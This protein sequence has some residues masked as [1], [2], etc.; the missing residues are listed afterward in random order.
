MLDR[1]RPA[2]RRHTAARRRPAHY[3]GGV[4]VLVLD[5]LTDHA[6]RHDVVLSLAPVPAGFVQLACARAGVPSVDAAGHSRP[7]LLRQ[8]DEIASRRGSGHVV[9]VGLV[10]GLSGLLAQEVAAAAPGQRLAVTLEQS[11][12][13]QVGPAGIR[14]ML[15]MVERG[16]GIRR[17]NEMLLR[18]DHPEAVALARAGIA[19]E[20]LTRWDSPG[21]TRAIG[22]LAALG[23]LP[24]VTRLPHRWL[25]RLSRH[26]R[27]AGEEAALTV[28]AARSKAWARA[29]VRSDYQAT[30]AVLA[31]VA[32]RAGDLGPGVL[33]LWEAI[34][35]AT[36]AAEISDAVTLGGLGDP[37]WVAAE[38]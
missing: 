27:S 19:A 29:R 6:R 25:G 37:Q 31:A 22:M 16:P 17:H 33:R 24:V 20:Y 9:G 38:G 11:S 32:V 18:L 10:P 26:R 28:R 21:Q 3:R 35:L 4:R 34:E 13:A 15:A 8:A 2:S 36:I 23:L 1:A 7:D 5:A 30:A 12:N 14:D